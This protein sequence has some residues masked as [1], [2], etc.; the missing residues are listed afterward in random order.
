MATSW[1]LQ[2][3]LSEDDPEIMALIKREKVRQR[4]GLELIAS[5]VSAHGLEDTRSVAYL[6]VYIELH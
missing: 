3:P 6:Y 4:R 2:E 1:T 5:E